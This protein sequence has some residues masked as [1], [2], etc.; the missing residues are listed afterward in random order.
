M[1]K[2][3]VILMT[4]ALSALFLFGC[5]EE[6]KYITTPDVPAAPVGVYSVTGDGFVDV[7]WQANND[8]G[9]TEAYGVYRYVGSSGGADQYELLGTVEASSGPVESY[10]YR[11]DDVVNGATYYYA[12]SAY[13]DYGESELSDPDAFDTPRPQGSATSRDFHGFPNQGGFDFSRARTVAADE[14][15]DIWFE[16]DP[17]LDAFFVWAANEQTDLQ[18][19]GWADELSNIGWGDPGDGEGWSDVGWM[20]L[21]VN[22]GYIV[23]T[24]DNHYAAILIKS[25]DFGTHTISFDWAYQTDEGNPELKRVPKTSPPHAENYGRR[26]GN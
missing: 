22:H 18:P 21:K 26:S 14:N 13:N 12:V 10:Y 11:D 25:T 16:Y 23:W 4:L 15:A 24:A 20:E 5:D 6:T 2:R 1:T 7:I 17:D 9:T 3:L 8:G 19:Y